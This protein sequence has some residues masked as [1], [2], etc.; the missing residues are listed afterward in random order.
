[1]THRYAENVQ[2]SCHIAAPKSQPF[3]FLSAPHLR[4]SLSNFGFLNAY[5]VRFIRT[6]PNISLGKTLQSTERTKNKENES[7]VNE[8]NI[9][10]PQLSINLQSPG[11][12]HPI[13]N[14]RLFKRG[15]STCR[16]SSGVSFF[17]FFS[18]PAI[19]IRWF[20]KMGLPQ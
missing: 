12:H 5:L 2:R 10:Y 13:F 17:R 1:M 11:N 20:P 16:I 15:H 7:I 3:V 9:Q 14:P 18:L 6:Y 4:C 19:F 8:S